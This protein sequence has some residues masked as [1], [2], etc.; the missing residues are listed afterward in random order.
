[1]SEWLRGGGADVLVEFSG[2]GEHDNGD[3]GV[4]ED[5]EFVGLL[6]EA[7]APL[8]VGH[9]PVRRVFDSL[10]LDLPSRH[11]SISCEFRGYF[12]FWI[13]SGRWRKWGVG[14]RKRK[15]KGGGQAIAENGKPWA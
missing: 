3:L 12:V 2:A 9:L 7:V 6:E 8:R 14:G 1:M 4:A 13:G 10:D 5:G 15:T 11:G